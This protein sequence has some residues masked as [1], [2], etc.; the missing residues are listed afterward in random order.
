ML[1]KSTCIYFFLLSFSAASGQISRAPQLGKSPVKEV[2]NAMTLEEKIN[3]VKGSGMRGNENNNGPVAGGIDGKVPGAAG[4]TYAIPRLGIPAIYMA[5]GPAGLRIDTARVNDKKRY[6][7][8]AFPTGT[9]LA[10]SWNTDLVKEVGKA[11]GKEVLEYGIDILL[12][13]GINIQR[14]PLCGR[15][16]EYYSEDPLL[17]G[18]LTSAMVTGIQSNGVGTSVKHFAVNNQENN[19]YNL[20][21]VIGQRALREIYL[22]GFEIAVKEA[23]PWTI[24]SSYNKLNG[25]Y[26]S[27]STSLLTAILRKEW[28]FKGIV[29]TDWY[30]GRK[31]VEQVKAGN[32][33]LMPGRDMEYTAIKEAIENKSL[34]VELLDRNIEKILNIVLH[35]PSFKK[36]KYSNNPDL[37]A[38]AAIARKAAAES[39]VLLK[40]EKAALPLNKSNILLFGNASYDTYI[41]GTGSGEVYKAYKVSISDGL[42]NTD[43]RPDQ[44]LMDSYKAHIAAEKRNRPQRSSLLA[45]E[46]LLAEKKFTIDEINSIADRGETAVITI[47]RTAGEG[48]DRNVD[49]DYYLQASEIELIENVSSVFHAKNK[50]VAVI[51]NIDAAVD[52]AAWRDKVDA[53]LL[54]WLPGQ[55]AGNAVAD[56]VTGKLSP[57]GHLSITFPMKYEDVPS[58][59]TFPGKGEK[60]PAKAVYNDGIYVGYRHNVSFDVKPAYEFG[61]GLSYTNFS[62]TGIKLNSTKFSKSISA[63]V[64][65]KNTGNQSGK[66][67]VQLYLSAP[68]KNMDKPERELKGFAKTKL[69]KPGEAQKLTFILT[70]K[71]LASFDAQKSAWIA[72][73]GAYTVKI[74]NSSNNLKVNQ[75]FTLE[76][77]LLVEQAN[78]VLAPTDNLAELKSAE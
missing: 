60:R 15:N 24:M 28:G 54:A 56:I 74:G 41:G 22:R 40:N 20:D 62:I 71:E 30:A 73:K 75:S 29:V 10:S 34:D 63:S 58:A 47:S 78:N 67:V 6:Y 70:P 23:D 33:L 26:T 55:E 18:Y 68:R 4:S 53:I 38:N 46:K 52:V 37:K 8:T 76:N 1:L 59:G 32:D 77:D 69:L 17:A 44:Q 31:P 64:N 21:A 45:T 50:R 13:P 5:D 7:S 57:S 16:F 42:Q 43:C 19:R 48:S 27:E 72:E 36:Y 35:S 3:L 51:L 9:S 12:A 66:E 49:K 14:N 65:V 11:M 39:L 61:F 25:V 2:I